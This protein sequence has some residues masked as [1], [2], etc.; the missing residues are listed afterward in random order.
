[1]RSCQ[2]HKSVKYMI[3]MERKVLNREAQA[4]VWL[5]KISLHISLVVE[6]GLSVVCLVGVV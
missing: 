2:T 6:A 5:P 3:N 4:A 1:M